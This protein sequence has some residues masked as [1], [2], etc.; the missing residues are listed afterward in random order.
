MAIN[1]LPYHVCLKSAVTL[2]FS[3]CSQYDSFFNYYQTTSE[4]IKSRKK[5][6]LCYESESYGSTCLNGISRDIIYVLTMLV[7]IIDGF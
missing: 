7:G 6:Y 2:K 1:D 5:C 3:D 4:L